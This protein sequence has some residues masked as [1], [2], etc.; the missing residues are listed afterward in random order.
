M[1]I[2]AA[3][4]AWARSPSYVDL[5]PRQ[6]GLL[7]LLCDELGPHHVRTAAEQLGVAKPVITRAVHAL[8]RHG[9]VARHKDPADGR[10]CLL[11]PTVA[12]AE[13]RAQMRRLG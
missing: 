1:D 7:G 8:S 12:G 6:L 3:S 5:T 11:T 2:A 4:L 10:N 13:L 9:L